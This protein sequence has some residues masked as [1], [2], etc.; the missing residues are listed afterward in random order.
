M[1][2]I[3]YKWIRYYL[4]TSLLI[5]AIVFSSAEL[6]AGWIYTSPISDVLGLLC[7]LFI[8]SYPIIVIIYAVDKDKNGLIATLLF[9]TGFIWIVL[10]FYLLLTIPIMD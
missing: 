8:I 4:I 9:L 2:L 7:V 10:I 1:K 3:K 6:K 5:A